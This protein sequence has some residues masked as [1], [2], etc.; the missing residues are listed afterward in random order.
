VDQI[1]RLRRSLIWAEGS[2]SDRSGSGSDQIDLG[3]G[4]IRSDQIKCRRDHIWDQR[5]V[6]RVTA[7]EAT[8]GVQVFGTEG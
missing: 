1:E 6:I 3:L 2:G 4:Q 5:Y 7:S 8:D